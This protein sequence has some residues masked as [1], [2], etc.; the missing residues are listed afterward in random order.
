M[1]R[2]CSLA[3]LVLVRSAAAQTV[4]TSVCEITRS[5]AAFDGK[6]VR[7]RATV[8]S[9]FEAFGIRD[10]GHGCGLIWLTYPGGGPVASTSFGPL[11]PNL[12]RPPVILKNNR[13]LKRFQKLLKAEMYPRSRGNLCMDCT[14]YEVT[15]TMTGRLDYAGKDHGFGHLNAYETRLVLESVSDVSAV[16]QSSHYDPKDFSPTPVHLPTGYLKGRVL[17]PDGRPVANAEVNVHSTEDVPPYLERFVEWTDEKGRFEVEVPPGTYLLGINV[18]TPPSPAVPFAATYYPGTA[19]EKSARKL[20]VADRQKVGGLTIRIPEQLRAR[21]VPVKVTW[22]DGKPVEDA[23]V[24]LTE[25]R[26]PTA[27][28]GGSVSH[29]VADGTFDLTGFEGIDY[30]LHAD[31]YVKPRYVPHCAEVRTLKTGEPIA[32]RLVMV[33]TREG[34]ICREKPPPPQG[35]PP[36]EG[37]DET[38]PTDGHARAA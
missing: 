4:Q 8:A 24:W 35:A 32:E 5:P 14:R 9:S 19:D 16:D 38:P 1:K 29:T 15:A 17:A 2:A 3:I 33:L 27:V 21:K 26:N 6:K 34:E 11:T 10:P 23:N 22:P 30:V 7:L 12:Q 37:K 25:I 13:Q 28:V 18:E 36:A 20:S 31:I